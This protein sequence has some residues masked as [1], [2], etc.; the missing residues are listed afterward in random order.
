MSA[1]NDRDRNLLDDLEH[2]VGQE[3]PASVL[4]FQDPKPPRRARGHRTRRHVLLEIS[5][6]CCCCSP[7]SGSCSASPA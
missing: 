3:D 6:G 4:Q 7:P 1:L 2:R 5:F